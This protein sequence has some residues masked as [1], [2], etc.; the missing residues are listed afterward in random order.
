MNSNAWQSTHGRPAG[1]GISITL[2]VDT[3]SPA[4]SHS[5]NQ[6]SPNPCRR[7]SGSH[8]RSDPR[9]KQRR[10]PLP[11]APSSGTYSARGQRS[12]RRTR[13]GRLAVPGSAAT[14]AA[15]KSAATARTWA[16]GPWPRREPGAALQRAARS[17][18]LR[19]RLHPIGSTGDD[20]GP[21]HPRLGTHSPAPLK[22]PA[23]SGTLSPVPPFP[24]PRGP[25]LAL[26]AVH[27]TATSSAGDSERRTEDAP[28]PA[29]AHA[30]KPTPPGSP[31]SSSWKHRG[32]AR[33]AQA[34]PTLREAY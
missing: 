27:G 26:T 30:P 1:T 23:N 6:L 33:L 17:M 5:S 19:T 14:A 9:R 16:P 10:L 21:A 13:R 31:T 24:G 20:T 12:R 7:P 11:H 2:R 22:R 34:A 3:P 18:T 32:R 4:R 25:H 8:P 29:R 28:R 15:A